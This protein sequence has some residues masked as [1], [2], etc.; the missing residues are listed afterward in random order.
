[1]RNATRT[2]FAAYAAHIASLNGVPSALAK[3]TVA[4]TVEQTLEDR[5]QESAAFLGEINVVPVDQ[6]SGEVLGL[7]IGTPAASRTNT[8]ANAREP[9]SIHSLTPRSYSCV[10]T[11]FDT[12]VRYQELDAWA[13]FPD[14]QPRLRNHV[15]MQIARDR[16]TIG[17]NGTSAAATTNLATNPLLQ[18]VN[19]GWLQKIRE[20]SPERVLSGVKVGDQAGADY[21]NLDALVFDAVGELLADWY[22]EDPGIVPILGRSLLTDKYL[23]LINSPDADAPTEKAALAAILTNRVLGGKQAK[24]VPFFPSNSIL[25]SKPSNLSIYWQNGTH[26]RYIQDQP[27]RDRI[28]DYLSIN[29]DYVIEDIEACALI[30]DILVPDG[31]GGWA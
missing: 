27:E 13:K 7:G 1:M 14:F 25:I 9:R 21:R 31:S 28:V 18:D 2:A 24:A 4:P 22:K 5:I 6:Q 12:Y 17:W 8:T 11:N 29:E 26:R 3:F 30:E 23:G 19:K 16:L 10:Q 15:T 20:A